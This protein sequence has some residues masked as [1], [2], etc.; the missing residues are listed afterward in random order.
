[1]MEAAIQGVGVALAPPMMFAR[2]LAE[3]KIRQPFAIG[4]T[5]GSYW[6]TRLQSRP[7]TAAMTAF[8]SWLV[9][10]AQSQALLDC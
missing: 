3:R 2:Q 9:D 8:R 5:T 4:I 6:L 10:A 1:M 7:E